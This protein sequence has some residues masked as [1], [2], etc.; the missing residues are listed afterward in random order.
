LQMLRDS[1]VTMLFHT[2]PVDVVMSGNGVESVI[3]QSPQGRHAIR[4][5]T[6]VDSTGLADIAAAAGAP[7][8]REEA[9]MGLQAFIG[10]V[11]DGKYASWIKSDAAPLGPEYRSWLE[12]IVGPFEK[13]QYPWD[14]WWPEMLGQ[15]YKPAYVRRCK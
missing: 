10:N 11:D 4:G 6:F 8:L 15:R 12:S 13:L 3:V 5:K 7:M 1:G 2:R 14:Q 9:F